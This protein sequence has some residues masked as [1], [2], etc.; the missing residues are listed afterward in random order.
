MVMRCN[1]VTLPHDNV[2][3]NVRR[4]DNCFPRLRT[5][6][7]AR[8]AAIT[9]GKFHPRYSYQSWAKLWVKRPSVGQTSPSD[10]YIILCKIN[11]EWTID[12]VLMFLDTVGSY[13]LKVW[14]IF[15]IYH[16]SRYKKDLL[17]L[18]DSFHTLI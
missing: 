11:L 3:R 7:S 16:P 12:Y 2:T 15:F 5:L 1:A 4:C 9:I 13:S 6:L 18:S 8:D 17:I 10:R 14:R